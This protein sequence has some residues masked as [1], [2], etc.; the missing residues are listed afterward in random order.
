MSY[1]TLVDAATLAAHLHDPKWV[2]FDC[3][4]DLA[5]RE[6]GARAYSEAHIPGARFAH[7]DDD[8]SG[9]KTGKNGRHPLPDPGTFAQWLGRMGV[10]A[11]KQV[12][13]YDAASGAFAARLWWMLKW[14]G[15]EAVALLD[16]GFN[17]WL[18]QNL[19]VTSERPQIAPAVFRANVRQNRVDAQY[20]ESC[21]DH[22]G[23]IIIDARSPERFR[24]E[25]ETLDPVGGHIPGARNHFFMQNLD[26]KQRFKPADALRRTFDEVLQGVPPESAVHQC[27][28]GVTACHNLLAMEIA[29]LKGSRLYPGS[30]S[31]WCSDPERPVSRA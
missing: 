9:K 2:V 20:I 23:C 25:N 7:V 27:G 17:A 10:D 31:E 22:G 28:S 24:G 6:A 26:D 18:E 3:R 13:A 21:L 19:P 1:T 16:G 14:L 8:L 5:D 4:H 30:W 15:H 11:D 29:G 12:V